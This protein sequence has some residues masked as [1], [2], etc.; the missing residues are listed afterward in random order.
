MK[1]PSQSWGIDSTI[2]DPTDVEGVFGVLAKVSVELFHKG[3]P[4][5]LK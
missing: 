1:S 5:L 2:A 3:E 4:I